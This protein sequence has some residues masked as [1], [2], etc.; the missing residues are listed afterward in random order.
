MRSLVSLSILAVCGGPALTHQAP[1]GWIYPVGCCHNHD[2]RQV[3]ADY[4]REARDGW[5]IV[6]TGELVPYTD[7][8]VKTSP[9]GLYHWCSAGGSET[10]RT[11]CLYVPPRGV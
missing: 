8:R 3:P 2:C 9:D 5:Q 4:V 6:P 10:G 1:T 11:I 7:E